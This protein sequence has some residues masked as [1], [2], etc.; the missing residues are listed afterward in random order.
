MKVR[1]E[2][3][4]VSNC[5]FIAIIF[6][7]VSIGVE[8][9]GSNRSRGEMGAPW[10]PTDSRHVAPSPM[11]SQSPPRRPPGA[12]PAYLSTTPELYT[13]SN[14]IVIKNILKLMQALK[15]DGLT[16]EEIQALFGDQ[17]GFLS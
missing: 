14:N 15:N 3:I 6:F 10:T 17:Q 8:S 7:V 2:V 11:P 16:E 1:H 9:R 5:H 12:A 4:F 13:V